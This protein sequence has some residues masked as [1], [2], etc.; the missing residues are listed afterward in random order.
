MGGTSRALFLLSAC[1]LLIMECRG[2]VPRVCHQCRCEYFLDETVKIDCS[3]RANITSIPDIYDVA[4][5]VVELNMSSCGPVGLLRP[6]SFLDYDY[7]QVLD[8]HKTL[9]QYSPNTTTD[10]FQGLE[11]LVYLDISCNELFA[12]TNDTYP[13]I[14][15]S[16]VSLKELRIHGTT[17]TYHKNDFPNEVISSFTNLHTLWVDGRESA[18]FGSVFQ[19]LENLTTIYIAGDQVY[20]PWRSREFC[21]VGTV[22]YGSLQNLVHV[23]NLLITKCGVYGVAEDAFKN[24]TSLV[25]LDM[26]SNIAL[27]VQNITA[28]LG[29]LANSVKTVVL[30]NIEDVGHMTCGIKVTRDMIKPFQNSNIT[31]I[32][33]SHNKLIS[34]ESTVFRTLPQ[35]IE[36]MYLSKNRLQMGLYLFEM[37]H[38]RNLKTIDLTYNYFYENI[39]EHPITNNAKDNNLNKNTGL[40][41]EEVDVFGEYHDHE[42]YSKRKY[43]DACPSTFYIPPE[44]VTVYLPP[45]LEVVNISYSKIGSPVYELFGDP[46]N[47]IHTI[48]AS[49]CLLHC[50]GGPVHGLPKLKHLDLSWNDCMDVKKQFFT[51]F[52]SLEVLDVSIN[53]MFNI[54]EVTQDG[55]LFKNNGNLTYLDISMNHLRRIPFDFFKHQINLQT[56]K[57]C[58]NLLRQLNFSFA[59]MKHLKRLELS[60]NHIET[61]DSRV[62]SDIETVLKSNRSTRLTINLDNNVIKCSCDNLEFFRLVLRTCGSVVVRLQINNCLSDDLNTVTYPLMTQQDLEELVLRLEQKCDNYLAFIIC[63][64]VVIVLFINVLVGVI[65]HRNRWQLWYWFY[66]RSLFYRN[67]YDSS[68]GCTSNCKYDV[69]VVYTEDMKGFAIE[70][71]MRKLRRM[72]SDF[73]LFLQHE[74]SVPGQ[75][76]VRYISNTVHVS[77]MVLIIVS[78]NCWNDHEWKVA[79]RMTHAESMYRKEPMFFGIL[80][81]EG[82]EQTQLPETVLEIQKR[83]Q[84]FSY[85]VT[86]DDVVLQEFW[87]RCAE[88]VDRSSSIV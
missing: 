54:I 46:N 50:W 47:I 82:I 49:K 88:I 45:Q 35:T 32:H 78:N 28:S 43:T 84:L 44:T 86:D 51:E 56:L 38:L 71:M 62:I 68:S 73:R 34:A 58:D 13:D 26:S 64:T 83:R 30:N 60:N 12:I 70:N 8:L 42:K 76:V 75:A 48:K 5:K 55:E 1:L 18:P 3:R 66:V 74:D 31:S 67:E 29:S 53:L 11:R 85:P 23:R 81:G 40:T 87:N 9:L 37:F 65:V 22:T 27:H 57:L 61:V 33:V 39:W 16:L 20:P 63:P 15:S 79:V 2:V 19:S 77:K 36:H 6:G 25:H 72:R 59:H 80:V 10:M 17:G 7:L 14:F 52:R 21:N 41:K 4:G 24:M 69:F